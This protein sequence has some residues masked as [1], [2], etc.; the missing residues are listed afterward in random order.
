MNDL[1]IHFHFVR[2]F[3]SSKRV[4]PMRLIPVLDLQHGV[5]VR[6]VG[7]RRAEYRP[8]KS[9]W[10]NND[11]PTRVA[12]ALIRAFR[13]RELYVADLDAIALRQPSWPTLA[14]DR[15]L[16]VNLW[17]D[18][19]VRFERDIRELA[20]ANVAGIV[21]GLETAAGPEV[22]DSAVAKVGAERIV[23]SLDL[24]DGRLLGRWQSW[25]A[26]NENDWSSIIAR[27]VQSGAKRVILLD[28]SRVGEGRG[29]GTEAMC[30]MITAKY[31]DLEIFCG[32]GIGHVDE[33]HRLHECGAS[34][35]LVAS[36]LHDGRI[37]PGD[38]PPAG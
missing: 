20:D 7:G 4:S 33:L 26:R 34:G 1:S 38:C 36:A 6:G 35:A 5:V 16:A 2:F 31:P 28:L 13:P 27:A 17:I 9:C 25:S 24:R 32:G 12:G 37:K 21:I 30:R 8:L 11:T 10:A 23:F 3:A 29:T 14:E 15:D 18:A 22:L 19:G